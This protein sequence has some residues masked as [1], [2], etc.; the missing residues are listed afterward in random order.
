MQVRHDTVQMSGIRKGY[1][2]I[3]LSDI[4]FSRFTSHAQNQMCISRILRRCR[5]MWNVSAVCITGDLV[6][7]KWNEHT[8]PDAMQL[9]RELRKIAPV[10]LSLGNHETDLPVQQRR[11]FVRA[12]QE[13]GAVILHNRSVRLGELYLTGL[14]LPGHVF[15]NIRGGYTDL[16]TITQDMV[17]NT[18]GGCEGHPHVLLAHSPLGL[19][20][21]G[22]WGA[23][24]ILSGHIHGGIVRIREQGILSP[25]RLFFPHFT[26]GM[27]TDAE[28]GA[29]MELTSGIGKLRF[30][31]PAEIVCVDLMPE[32]R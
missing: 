5:T 30:N 26:K 13:S 2:L 16:S 15:R 19:S 21:Y 10:I 7:R 12:M 31:N 22:K 32:K 6:S 20:A 4:H 11:E 29:R 1:R 8:L 25:E 9:V 27:Y 28:T 3:H 23:D 17:E 14:T 18:L 24:V